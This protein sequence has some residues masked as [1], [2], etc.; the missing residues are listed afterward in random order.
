MNLPKHR[1]SREAFNALAAGG[2]GIGAVRDLAAA[3]YSKH[4]T[5]LH[6]VLAAARSVD[7]E[8]YPLARRGWDLLTA[9]QRHDCAAADAVIRHPAVAAW[10]LRTVRALRGEPALPGA[11]PGGLGAVAAAAA[12][13]ARHPSEIE[14]V[15][16]GESVVLP[17]LGVAAVAGPLAIVKTT[18]HYAEVSTEGRR[19]KIP[20]NPHQNAPGWSAL[21]QVS[22]GPL[23]ILIDD[24][25]PF[26]MPASDDVS[27]RLDRLDFKRW[28]RM[29]HA[30]WPL[31]EQHPGVAAEVAAITASVVPLNEPESGQI[32]SSSSETF[33]AIAMSEPPD[34]YMCAVTL[35]H[36]IQHLKLAALLD[37]V[38]LTLRDDGSRYYAPWRDDPRP[39]SGLLQGAYAY[40]GVSGFWR[41]QRQLSDGARGLQADMEFARWRAGAARAV[42][43]LRSSGRLTP[44]GLLFTHGMKST[45]ALWQDEPVAAEAQARA[46]H[47]ADLHMARWQAKYGRLPA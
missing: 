30:T 9:V 26:R 18:A 16:T 13:R 29:L 34:P 42:E 20:A 43:T 41:R 5:L 1:I 39:V 40:L 19:V 47:E 12:I 46:R 7:H 22:V 36:E 4:V 8:H 24:L 31:L 35:A 17:S 21:R 44:I 6:G 10:A 37:I 38:P 25:D 11:E 3:Q 23:N 2:G 45:L 14:I 27:P 33:G 28:Q 32:S 15:T